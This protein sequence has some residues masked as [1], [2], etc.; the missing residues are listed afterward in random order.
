MVD[1]DQRPT[2]RPSP[3]SSGSRLRRAW[4]HFSVTRIVRHS[5]IAVGPDRPMLTPVV[6]LSLVVGVIEALLLY[7]VAKLALSL[8]TGITTVD[9]GAGPLRDHAVPIR[10]V[11]LGTLALVVLVSLLAIPLSRTAA[12]VSAATLVRLRSAF[13]DGFLHSSWSYRSSLPEGHLQEL[14]GEYCT[15]AERLVQQLSTIVVS[16]CGMALLILAAI[17]IAPVP[18]LVTLVGLSVVGLMLLPLTQRL[19]T[20]SS[21]YVDINK[22]LSSEVAQTSRVA[23][24]IASFRVE[25][26]VAEELSVGIDASGVALAKFRTISRLTPMLY[27]YGA[28]GLIVAMIGVVVLLHQSLT[29][30]APVLLLIIRALSYVKQLQTATQVGNEVLPYV[31]AIEVELAELEANRAVTGVT[32]LDHLTRLSFES[33]SFEYLADQPV[34]V[35]VELA[36]DQGEA[37]GFV[38][39]SGG[40]KSTLTQLLLQLRRPTTG[41]IA[42][43][44]AQPEGVGLD[45]VSPASWARLVGLVPQDN[46]LISG[47]VADNIRFYR[48]EFTLD[49]VTTAGRAA[50]LHDEIEALPDGYQTRIGPGARN[51]SGGQRQRLGIARA[52]LGQPEMLVLDEPTSALDQ[53]SEQL[54][55]RTLQELK[56]TTTLVIVAHRPATLEVC[57]RILRVQDHHVTEVG[58]ADGRAALALDDEAVDT[59]SDP[60]LFAGTQTIERT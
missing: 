26:P 17:I 42:V 41:R 60:A 18:G 13:T 2:G 15:R 48:A 40:G 53:R 51:L 12:D 19:R 37:V 14:L 54:I 11:V 4:D 10:P 52:L 59:E 50:H 45:D 6:A 28:L 20:G 24:E 1:R 55:Q 43:G 36:I 7:L 30:V 35:D 21:V 47:T 39:P 31:L 32:P 46:Q 38:G 34:L 8:S 3:P 5:L 49:Q 44:G 16:V 27:Q 29:A 56:G 9:L 23:V 57:D 58:L 33:V 22:D 25:Q